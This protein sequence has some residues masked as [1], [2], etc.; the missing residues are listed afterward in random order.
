MD[1]A[2]RA[3]PDG[4]RP[5]R[6]QVTYRVEVDAADAKAQS[7]TVLKEILAVSRFAHYLKG[8]F[9]DKIGSF[10]TASAVESC[11]NQWFDGSVQ[12][13]DPSSEARVEVRE[14]SGE[15]DAFEAVAV[16]RRR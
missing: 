6:V 16:L 7:K 15:P 12:G 2:I 13:A 4:V 3:H 11:F 8:V 5:A 9:R 14:V 10:E 1:E